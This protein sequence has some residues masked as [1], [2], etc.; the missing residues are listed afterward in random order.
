MFLLRFGKSMYP[1]ALTHDVGREHLVY[2]LI[3][4]F[5]GKISSMAT[6]RPNI[7]LVQHTIAL[8]L[9]NRESVAFHQLNVR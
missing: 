8:T 3:L 5:C 9:P 1:Q 6:R 7:S 4:S 2:H